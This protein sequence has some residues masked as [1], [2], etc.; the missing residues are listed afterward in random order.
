MVLVGWIIGRTTYTYDANNNMIEDLVQ[1]W[2]DTNWVNSTR[3][4]Y[5]Y[6]SITKIEQLTEVIESYSLS[7]NYP[8]P[9]NPST[10]IKYSIPQA[11]QC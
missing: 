7:N 8:N 1:D 10:T 9:F 4:I 3:S 6:Q 2:N 5:T 11:K